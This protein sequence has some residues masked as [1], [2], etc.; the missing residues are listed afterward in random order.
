LASY[1]ARRLIQTI[2]VILLVT[3]IT[4]LLIHVMPGDPVAA[5]LSG[6]GQ[7][8]QEQIDA[9]RHEL[10]L[11]RPIHVQYIHWLSNIVRGDL[12]KSIFYGENVSTLMVERLPITF[13][14]SALGFI[15]AVI[16]G[17]GAGVV[18]A[19][20]RGGWVDNVVSLAANI[21]IGVPVFW[22]G[23]VGILVIGLN[24]HWLPTSGYTS[25][26]KDLHRSL[27]Q[28][29]MPVICLAV[30]FIAQLTRQTRSSMLETIRQD[31]IRT[32]RAKGL[33]EN[34]VVFKHALKNAFIPVITLMGMQIRV[35]FGGSV[36]VETVFNVPGV[37]R[38]LVQ[39]CL[40]KDILVVQAVVLIMSVVTCFANLAVD[41]S[42]G[43]FDPRIRYE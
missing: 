32:A 40:G 7:V 33:V 19:I 23:I 6:T 42:Y 27:S 8:T 38:L 41:I 34:V 12:G 2:L 9:L 5:L 20:K 4:F 29:I 26:F 22:L 43:W 37:G 24:L 1:I 25:P 16:V 35:L 31:Y 15:L 36:L 39:S 3:V 28:A 13:Y 11:D 17:I 14:L 10:W 21:G 18:S 30:P